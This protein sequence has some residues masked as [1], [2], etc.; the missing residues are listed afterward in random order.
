MIYVFTITP[1][2]KPRMVQSDKWRTNPRH[3]DPVRRQR[4]VVT[5]YWQYKSDLQKL[6][7]FNKFVLQETIDMTAY[8]PMPDSWSM[9]KKKAMENMPHQQKPDGDNV[10]KGFLDALTTSDEKIWDKRVRKFWGLKGKIIVQ[11]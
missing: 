6:C 2:G 10:L 11:Q 3:P 1:M 7:L 4:E 9:K 8:F 5:R